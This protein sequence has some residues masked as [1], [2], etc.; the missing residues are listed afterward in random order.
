MKIEI[1]NAY[2]SDEYSSV[3]LDD[4]IIDPNI[5]F[6]SEKYPTWKELMD[7]FKFKFDDDIDGF[8]FTIAC[9]YNLLNIKKGYIL[10]DVRVTNIG[11]F[12]LDIGEFVVSCS[13]NGSS[14]N[15]RDYFRTRWRNLDGIDEYYYFDIPYPRISEYI[16]QFKK[17]N[18]KWKLKL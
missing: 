1:L 3:Y 11:Y 12:F 13:L 18:K 4:G 15:Q 10:F 5:I 17:D 6:L 9:L 14:K 16:K 8:N 7:Q 2:Y